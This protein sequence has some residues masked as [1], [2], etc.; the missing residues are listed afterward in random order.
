MKAIRIYEHG[1]P[2][3]LL[4][5]DI[6][7]P[8]PHAREVLVKNEAIGVNF[9]DTQ[10]RAGLYY[11]VDLPLILG[12]E[13]AGVVEAVGSEVTEFA[14]GDRVGYAG[15]LGG[16]YADYTVVPEARLVPVPSTVDAKMAAAS[17]LQGMTAHFLVDEAYPVK[18]GDAVLIHAAAGGVGL[19]LVQMAKMR[20]ATVIG[21]VSSA[22]KAQVAREAGADHLIISTQMDFEMETMRLTGG[23]GVHVVYDSVGRTTFDKSL[24]VLRARGSM[25]VFG[26]SSGPV[27]PFDVNR[28]SGITGSGNKGSLFL[29]FATLND[30]AARR[31]DLLRRARDVLNWIAEGTLTVRLAGTFPLAQA[32]AAHRLLERREVAG[33]L[34]LLP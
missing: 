30:Y 25:V 9:V 17:L 33:K 22:E 10:H 29:T 2:E 3:I 14:V 7:T 6:A 32:A 27:P 26:L 20:G 19:L 21:I 4:I 18:E 1:G 24:N 11:P 31:Q 16:V 5:T 28:L 8:E 15:Y 23:R 12:I 34:L 13:A